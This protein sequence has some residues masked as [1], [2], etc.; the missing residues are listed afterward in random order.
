MQTGRIIYGLIGGLL[1][2]IG[3]AGA[4]D[5]IET[6]KNWIADGLE[7]MDHDVARWVF[8]IVG[9]GSIAIAVFAPKLKTI[10][11]EAP[12]I[13][14]I[15]SSHLRK[16]Y[17]LRT[18]PQFMVTEVGSD[19]RVEASAGMTAKRVANEEEKQQDVITDRMVYA[20]EV[21]DIN[22]AI[23]GRRFI[24]C[25][26]IGPIIILPEDHRRPFDNCLW[27]AG[28]EDRESIFLPRPMHPP[29]GVCVC[30]DT[31]FDHCEFIQVAFMLLP[32]EIRTIWADYDKGPNS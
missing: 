11:L 32:D 8:V 30:R 23:V 31:F 10:V 29:Y 17:P 19:V 5:D 4:P 22:L 1:T 27:D 12:I 3:I 13:G 18:K 26:I 2:F 15:A 25:T 20:H 16:R 9:V 24:R 21:M 7:I 28:P 6:W 14:P